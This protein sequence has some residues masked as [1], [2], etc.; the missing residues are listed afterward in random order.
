MSKEKFTFHWGHGIVLTFILF[1]AFMAYFYVQ[2]SSQKIDLVGD[3]YYE[4][5]QKFQEKLTRISE[6]KRLKNK[7]NFTFNPKRNLITLNVP[8]NTNELIVHLFFPGD[9][10]KDQHLSF[11]SP[12]S[13]INIPVNKLN[14]GKWKITFSYF[15]NGNNYLEEQ[16]FEIN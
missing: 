6:T 11:P 10:S 5:G 2:M 1:A 8:A 15:L 12:D 7:V 4:D 9:A 3:H 16:I 14:K 13:N